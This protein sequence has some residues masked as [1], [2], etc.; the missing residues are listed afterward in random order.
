MNR[1]TLIAGLASAT[2]T[3][4]V[5]A[6]AGAEGWQHEFAPYVFFAGMDGKTAIGNVSADVDVSFGDIWDNLKFGAMGAYLGRKD[7]FFVQLDGIYMDLSADKTGPNGLVFGD[8]E[9]T[10]TMIEADAGFALT[11]RI[12]LFAGLRYNKLDGDVS[13]TGP[14][15]DKHSASEKEDWYDPVL[16]ARYMHPFNE[17]WS[18]A[19]RGDIGGFN[20]GSD[21]AWQVVASVRWQAAERVGVIAAYRYLDVDYETGFGASYFKYDMAVSGPALGVVFTF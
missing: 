10:Q 14:L 16:G 6:S 3:A 21:F 13:I 12:D 20:F 2:L 11:E 18:A 8:V 5:P 9:M 15:N 17:K 7:R 4:A 1:I 19:L